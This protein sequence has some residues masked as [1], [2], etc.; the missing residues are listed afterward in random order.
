[1]EMLQ[2]N[3]YKNSCFDCCQ[4]LTRR[5][6]MEEEIIRHSIHD[7]IGSRTI[8]SIYYQYGDVS[9]NAES[10]ETAP[11]KRSPVCYNEDIKYLIWV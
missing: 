7:A 9:S 1:M 2:I 6:I 8:D 10:N 5:C 11:N 3:E 4:F